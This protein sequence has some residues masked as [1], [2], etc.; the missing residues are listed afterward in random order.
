MI[1][2]LQSKEPYMK[3]KV[4]E[5]CRLKDVAISLCHRLSTLLEHSGRVHD[6]MG[7][8]NPWIHHAYTCTLT[9]AAMCTLAHTNICLPTKH[10]AATG[11]AEH[12]HKV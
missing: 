11:S 10:A 9:A 5:S 2:M 7:N 3:I 6:H 1:R 8:G 4:H 12:S